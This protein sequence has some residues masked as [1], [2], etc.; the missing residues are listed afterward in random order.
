MLISLTSYVFRSVR[1]ITNKEESRCRKLNSQTFYSILRSVVPGVFPNLGGAGC[2]IWSRGFVYFV[3]HLFLVG[4]RCSGRIFSVRLVR[5]RS[6]VQAI[7]ATLRIYKKTEILLR[8]LCFLL[9][10]FCLVSA[11]LRWVFGTTSTFARAAGSR[12]PR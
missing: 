10:K 7:S 9:F 5:R 8:S 4:P 2:G 11:L 6:E 12:L 1:N 3:V